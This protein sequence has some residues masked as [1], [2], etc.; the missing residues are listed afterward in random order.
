MFCRIIA[1]KIK[2]L[3]AIRRLNRDEILTKEDFEITE[4]YQT[5]K[6]YKNAI[7]DYN[8]IKGLTPRVTIM[9][10]KQLFKHQFQEPTII[11]KGEQIIIMAKN[12]GLTISSRGIAKENGKKGKYI[13]VQT[14]FN[15]KIIRA[16]VVAPKKVDLFIGY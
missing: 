15:N 5:N 2:H 13:L 16:R 1:R 7:Q 14:L 8:E 3:H 12:K 11:K 6:S 9:P 10:Y 4:F